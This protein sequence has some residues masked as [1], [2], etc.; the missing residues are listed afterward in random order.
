[1][2]ASKTLTEA[3]VL[4]ATSEIDLD[5]EIAKLTAAV[6]RMAQ[7]Q[8]VREAQRRFQEALSTRPA[9]VKPVPFVAQTR[10]IVI[11][12]LLRRQVRMILA[13]DTNLEV[14]EVKGFFESVFILTAHTP[15]QSQELANVLRWV[16]RIEAEDAE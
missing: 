12:A 7:P 11:G 9:A 5:A 14:K 4:A 2:T 6:D 16:S 13:R 15:K 10:K 1:M 8:N 3:D